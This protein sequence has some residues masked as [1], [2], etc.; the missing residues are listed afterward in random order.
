MLSIL[1]K[2]K[3]NINFRLT[4]AIK[5]GKITNEFP[6]NPYIYPAIVTNAPKSFD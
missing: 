6:N 5:F 2:I 1:G 4:T 3:E